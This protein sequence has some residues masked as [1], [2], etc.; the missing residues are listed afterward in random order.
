M[1]G[2]TV[3]SRYFGGSTWKRNTEAMLIAATNTEIKM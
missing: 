3:S 1:N 2:D